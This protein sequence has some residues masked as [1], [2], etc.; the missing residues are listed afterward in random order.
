M[1]LTRTPRQR[2]GYNLKLSKA[3]VE[4]LGGDWNASED[5]DRYLDAIGEVVRL[6]TREVERLGELKS[7]SGEE[8]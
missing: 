4:I 3:E 2:T 8:D 6:A 1:R 5:V 7:K